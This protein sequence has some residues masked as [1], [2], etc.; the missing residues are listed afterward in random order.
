MKDPE[1]YFQLLT[2]QCTQVKN[3]QFVNDE[4]VDVYYIRG[5]IFIPTSG[6]TNVG[7]AAFTTA[8]ARLKLYSVLEHLET[9]VLYFDTDSVIFT[10]Q[11]NEWIPPLG[12]YL[13]SSRLNWMMTTISPVLSQGDQKS[14]PFKP[15]TV[16]Q[17]IKC[18]ALL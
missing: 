8:H 4:C 3:I 11:P 16:K 18:E 14:M 5:D 10:S 1:R 7:I 2:C 12:D 13:E 15:R 6:K 9:I 17:S